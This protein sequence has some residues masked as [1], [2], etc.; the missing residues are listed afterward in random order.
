M[1]IGLLSFVVPA[2][3]E[4]LLLPATL[5]SIQTACSQ[6]RLDYEVV[7]A[8][9]ASTDR[10]AEVALAAGARVVTVAHRQI[11]RT[12]NAGAAEA[13][14]EVL[15]FIDADTEISA[16]YVADAVH[17][18]SCGA[19]GGGAK[20][21]FSGPLPRYAATVMRVFDWLC[22]V[23]QLSGGCCLFC[24][25]DVFHRVGGFDARMFAGEEL[26]L[27]RQLKR[28]GRFRLVRTPVLTSGR[29][30]RM[31]SGKELFLIVVRL[32]L[33]GPRAVTDKRGL[34]LWYQRREEAPPPASH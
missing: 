14:G 16:G 30:L 7:V 15:L 4:E 12:R 26:E 10:T 24:R 3:N 11:S 21:I 8:D 28:H 9:D 5:A 6:L 34:E 18:I 29:K 32:F 33:K 27:G 20:F 23:L 22:D 13:R 19:V 31:Y 1:R 17:A 25:R 2:H